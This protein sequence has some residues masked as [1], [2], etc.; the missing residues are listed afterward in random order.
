MK[1]VMALP[2]YK[3]RTQAAADGGQTGAKQARDELANLTTPDDPIEALGYW[4]EISQIGKARTGEMIDNARQ[5]DSPIPW[6]EIGAA[7][8]VSPDAARQRWNYYLGSLEKQ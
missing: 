2:N 3:E 7:L 8:G 5:G 6:A 1:R 4:N